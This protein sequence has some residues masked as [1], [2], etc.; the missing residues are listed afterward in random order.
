ME[1]PA[2]L[3]RLRQGQSG[4]EQ[5]QRY[6]A[7]RNKKRPTDE[8]EYAP[9]YVLEGGDETI[10]VEEFKALSNEKSGENN[11]E[12]K[13]DVEKTDAPMTEEESSINQ[14]LAVTKEKILE[15]G[16]KVNK[17]KAAKMI[18]AEGQEDTDNKNDEKTDRKKRTGG[19]PKG[20]QK[21]K[22]SFG[23]DE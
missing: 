17:R 20:K 10:T 15:A 4:G 19:K 11:G 18:G 13:E 8:D 21:V 12:G 6:I 7:P 1:E 3:R 16:S 2:F 5:Q 9:T 14:S 22:L 23:D